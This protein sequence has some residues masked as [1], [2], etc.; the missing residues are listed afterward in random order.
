[1][2]SGGARKLAHGCADRPQHGVAHKLGT[3]GKQNDLTGDGENLV[4]AR[5]RKRPV[6]QSG[7][8]VRVAG[9]WAGT[10]LKKLW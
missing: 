10:E 8:K 6:L 5:G 1:M 7:D 3:G 9:S 4:V 2:T